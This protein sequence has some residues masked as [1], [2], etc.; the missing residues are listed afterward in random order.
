MRKTEIG[1]NKLFFYF[2]GKKRS[3]FRYHKI[4]KKTHIY[5]YMIINLAILHHHPPIPLGTN[6]L[7]L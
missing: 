5:I 7:Y 2:V 4:G 1:Y 3:N 6:A